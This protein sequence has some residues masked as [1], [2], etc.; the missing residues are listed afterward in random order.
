MMEENGEYTGWSL[1]QYD[2]GYIGGNIIAGSRTLAKKA[3]TPSDDGTLGCL[4]G[5]Y[6]TVDTSGGV[7]ILERTAASG[8][9]QTALAIQA[10]LKGGTDY[11]LSFDVRRTDGRDNGGLFISLVRGVLYSELSTGKVSAYSKQ[12]GNATETG[13][14]EV[15]PGGEWTRVWLHFR[16]YK[17][18]TASTGYNLNI[19]VFGGDVSGKSATVQIRKPKLEAMA[20]PSEWTEQNALYVEAESVAKK[21]QEA[22]IDIM[23]GHIVLDAKKTTVTG[24]LTVQGAIT[25]STSYVGTD[26]T[27]W[28]PNETGELEKSD[29]NLFVSDG[30][31]LFI[32]INMASIK[33]VQVQTTDA[34]DVGDA[35]ATPCPALVTLP[36]Y[37]AVDLGCGVTL[38]AY[39]RSGTHVLLRNGFSLAYNQ[40]DKSTAWDDDS[41][42]LNAANVA[43]YVCVDPRLLSLSNYADGQPIITPDGRES[44]GLFTTAEWFKGCMYLNGRRG[45]WLV[46]L[47]GQ[48]VELVSVVSMWQTGTN[49]PTPYLA[50][51]VVGGNDMDWLAKTMRVQTVNDSF[52]GVFQS[53]PTNTSFMGVGT[54]DKYADAFFGPRQLSDDY[55][56]GLRDQTV[57]VMLSDKVKPY[58]NVE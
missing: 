4:G 46:L 29:R 30:N 26:G 34:S 42:R 6:G 24:D 28:S 35:S 23:T 53:A 55:V 57:R 14:M 44:G 21:L 48:Q 39:R 50:W 5:V 33:S 56:S 17:D 52:D 1:S 25:D 10:F 54:I 8:A 18:W 49:T 37:D 43:M 22:G 19:G 51:Y 7:A 3:A 32:P 15:K 16:L 11:V 12:N 31:G 2:Y 47:P 38:P 45:R 58:V 27:L 20:Y 9:T 13:Y 36:M 41:I 40:W